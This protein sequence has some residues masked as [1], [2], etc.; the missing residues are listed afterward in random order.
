MPLYAQRNPQ[1]LLIELSFHTISQE[2]IVLTI[3]YQDSTVIVLINYIAFI[4]N[5]MLVFHVSFMPLC[6]V[7]Q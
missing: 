4:P 5:Y 7:T 3:S 2:I 1:C 6:P